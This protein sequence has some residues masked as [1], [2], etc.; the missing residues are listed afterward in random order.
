MDCQ[1]QLLHLRFSGLERVHRD[2]PR[3][4]TTLLSKKAAAW[5]CQGHAGMTVG[6]TGISSGY[7]VESVDV[8]D[9]SDPLPSGCAVASEAALVGLPAATE[10]EQFVSFAEWAFGPRGLPAL[11]VLAFGDFSHEDRYPGQQFLVRRVEPARDCSPKCIPLSIGNLEGCLPFYPVDISELSAWDGMSVD[12]ARF[13]SA[14]P[15]SG[16]MESPYEF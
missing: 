5:S 3:E 6:L 15:G 10:A 7:G 13:L 2:L 4:I 9:G 1:I 12:G 16:L 14:C 8:L 11:K